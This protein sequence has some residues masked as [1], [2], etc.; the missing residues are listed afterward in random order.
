[1]GGL[2][3]MG[4]VFLDRHCNLAVVRGMGLNKIDGTLGTASRC[5]THI[6][7]GGGALKVDIAHVVKIGLEKR[8]PQTGCIARLHAFLHINN[9]VLEPK[10]RSSW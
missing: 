8:V 3:F 6:L 1:M 2:E 5:A 9:M 10:R 7:I 4:A